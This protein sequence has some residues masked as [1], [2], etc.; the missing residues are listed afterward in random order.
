MDARGLDAELA[1][2][3]GLGQGDVADV[4]FDVEILVLDPGGIIEI[5]R[6]AQDFFT[7]VGKPMQPAFKLRQNVLEAYNPA[8]C[9]GLIVNMQ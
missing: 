4:V 6:H 8:G 9:G 2:V 3:A 7:K 5:E 1:P